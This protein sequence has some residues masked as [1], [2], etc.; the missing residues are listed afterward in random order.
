MSAHSSFPRM[1][2]LTNSEGGT[3]TKIGN[4][5]I[6]TGYRIGISG[7]VYGGSFG[8]TFLVPPMMNVMLSWTNYGTTLYAVM[9]GS[10]SENIA[11]TKTGYSII[12]ASG[13]GTFQGGGAWKMM[14]TAVGMI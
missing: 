12:A 7:T 9:N 5:M 13:Q 11:T 4:M 2:T 6:I 1:N 14:Y 10:Y 3:T 8:E